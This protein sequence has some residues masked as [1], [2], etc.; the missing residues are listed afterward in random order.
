[1]WISPITKVREFV[2]FLISEMLLPYRNQL[3][4]GS[5]FS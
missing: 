5:A 2:G 4:I 1:M 3:P